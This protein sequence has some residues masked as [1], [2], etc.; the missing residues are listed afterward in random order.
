M[1]STAAAEQSG[2][3][4]ELHTYLPTAFSGNL[5]P[6]GGGNTSRATPLIIDPRA[7]AG[8]CFIVAS[9]GWI[10]RSK[11]SVAVHV[12]EGDT[13][14]VDGVVEDGTTPSDGATGVS[15]HATR[16]L[17]VE[18]CIWCYTLFA[19]RDPASKCFCAYANDEP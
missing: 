10:A 6:T 14:S 4:V 11:G 2:A 17:P 13:V 15:V 1:E 19:P 5:D 9:S 3:P 18:R 7:S 16:A 12:N 8:G